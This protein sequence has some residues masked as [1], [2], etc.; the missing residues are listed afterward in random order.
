[1]LIYMLVSR[2]RSRYTQELKELW[3]DRKQFYRAIAA[4]FLIAIN[5]LTYIYAIAN[6][7]ATESSL[8]YYMMPLVSV[9]LALVILKESLTPVSYT[10]L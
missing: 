7:H 1:M 9:L 2:N 10:H 5:W 4:A 3:L 6:G 8:G